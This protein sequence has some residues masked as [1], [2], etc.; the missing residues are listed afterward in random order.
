MLTQK[1]LALMQEKE[2]PYIVAAKL[3]SLPNE[4]KEKI[5]DSKNFISGSDGDS[6]FETEYLGQRLM[7]TYSEKRARKDAHDR[8]KNL[9]KATQQFAGK[10]VKSAI[11][12]HYARYSKIEGGDNRIVIDPE[13]VAEISRSS[14]RR[15]NE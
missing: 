3:K 2:Q 10:P 1:N 15:F 5:L 8:A 13:R 11:R 6:W 12:G 4:I 7:I 14:A 9:E